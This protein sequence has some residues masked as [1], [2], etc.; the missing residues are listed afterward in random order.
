MEVDTSYNVATNST[1]RLTVQKLSGAE[2]VAAGGNAAISQADKST[3]DLAATGIV[4]GCGEVSLNADISKL[5][6]SGGVYYI[7]GTRYI[8]AGGTAI[9][10]TI[11]G[12]DSSTW[13]GLDSSGLVYSATKWSSIQ[14]QTILPLARLQSVQGDSGPGSDLITP[15]DERYII[16]ETGYLQRLWQEEAIGALYS[17]GGTYVESSTALQVDQL[18][19]VLYTAQRNRIDISASGDITAKAVYHVSG[20]ITV[21]NDATLV[22][23]KYFDDGTDID[24]LLTN[25][26]AT[27]TLLKTPKEE[28]NFFLIYG[29]TA[30]SS[31]EEA[32]A[33]PIN[34]SVFTSQAASGLIAVANF[35]IRGGSTNIES[36]VD[37]RPQ[38][39]GSGAT[40][41]TSITTL[42][43]A[44]DNSSNP[45]FNSNR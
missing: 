41:T 32:E 42:Q 37:F 44:Y 3:D 38:I 17:S 39:V 15:V 34:Y 8:Y 29:D 19:G 1:L 25:K 43:A 10:P 7:Q 22:M 13:V 5:D 16:S 6:I 30:Y 11:A 35:T 18:S 21:Q 23:P 31:Q 20:S 33:A 26:W 45:W 24:G 28:D 40:S 12:G 9:V 4:N 27:H 14:K 36:I 2:T